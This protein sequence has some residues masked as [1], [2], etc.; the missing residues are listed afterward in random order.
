MQMNIYNRNV[1]KMWTR[2]EQNVNKKSEQNVNK[3]MG[4]LC[5]RVYLFMLYIDIVSHYWAF[6]AK[7]STLLLLL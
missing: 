7:Q 2:C 6:T 1:N 3:N 5:I 4:Y